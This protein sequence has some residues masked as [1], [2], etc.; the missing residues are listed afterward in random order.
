MNLDILSKVS[1]PLRPT[2]RY[3][4]DTGVSPVNSIKLQAGRLCH[5]Y[6]LSYSAFE[7]RI[8]RRN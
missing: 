8:G 7:H 4:R 1:K 5:S 3:R 6:Q 2:G